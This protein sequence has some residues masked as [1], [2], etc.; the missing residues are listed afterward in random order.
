MPHSVDGKAAVL[1]GFIANGTKEDLE[2]VMA[3]A[4]EAKFPAKGLPGPKGAEVMVVFGPNSD[5]QAALAFYQRVK[6]PEFSTLEI[7]PIL[8]SS[9]P[10]K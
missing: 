9:R 4:T 8:T 6:S 3:A 10:S 7:Q 2:R 5:A 1:L